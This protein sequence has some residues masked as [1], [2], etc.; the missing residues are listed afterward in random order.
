MESSAGTQEGQEAVAKRPLE[1]MDLPSEI[2]KEII[3]HASQAD[4]IC[5]SLVSKHFRELAAAQLYRNFNI[6]FPDEDDPQYDSPIDGLAGGLDTF[7]TS[8]YDYAQHLRD[9]SLDTLSAGHK[10]E[11]AYKPYLASLSCG[12]FMNTLLLLTLRKAKKLET[13]KWNIRVELSR[14]VYKELHRIESLSHLHIRLQEGPSIYEAPPPLPYHGSAVPPIVTSPYH[15]NNTQH[16]GPNGLALSQIIPQVTV[17]TGPPGPSGFYPITT[18]IG[19]GNNG[20]SI[21][22][23]MGAP[24]PQPKPP[25]PRPFK[26]VTLKNEPPTF[27]GFKKLKSLSVLDIDS[28]DIITEIKSCVRNSAG[29]LQKVKLSFS[30]K[31]ASQARKPPPE[32]DPEDSDVDDDFQVAPPPMPAYMSEASGPAKAFRAQEERKTQESVL[33]RIFDLEVFMVKKAQK[34]Q[35]EKEKGKEKETKSEL[36]KDPGQEFIRAIKMVANRLVKEL[37]DESDPADVKAA[38]QGILDTIEAAA[39]KYLDSREDASNSKAGGS[40]SASGP[41]KPN[42][43]PPPPPAS[44]Q[45]KT[46]A[47]TPSSAAAQTPTE[48]SSLFSQSSS[49]KVTESQKGKGIAPEDINIE[50]PEEQLSLDSSDPPASLSAANEPVVITR[51][52]TPTPAV[53]SR[54]NLVVVPPEASKAMANLAAQRVNFRT[55]AEKL[56]IFEAQ[57]DTL[58]KHIAQMR[59][60]NSPVDVSRIAEAEKEMSVISHNIQDIHKELLTVE[61]EIGDAEKQMPTSIPVDSVEV[62]NQRMIDYQRRT[63]GVPLQSF[64]VY[65]MPVK[66]SILSK[67][68]D[69]RMLRSLTL[70][71]VGIQAPIWTHLTNLNRDQPLP[72]RKIFT[73][74]VT[75]AF[76]TFVYE[77]EELEQLFMLERDA[78]Y[79]PEP[80]S[81]KTLVTMDMIRKA[82]LKK[83]VH[84]IKRLMIK[85]QSNTSWDLD[86]KSILL[87]C[88][89]GRQLE[90]LSCAMSI[91]SLHTFM[92]RIPGLVNLRALHIFQLRNEDTC[93]WVMREAKRFLIDNLSHYPELKLEWISIDEDDRVER[94]IRP[95]DLPKRDRRKHS[96]HNH[97]GKGK[98]KVVVVPGIEGWP[99]NIGASSSTMAPPV[100]GWELNSDSEDD[101]DQFRASKIETVGELHFYDVY[102]VKIFKKEVIKGRL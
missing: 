75:P 65:L 19:F 11:E 98:Q 36:S 20:P 9:L 35:R 30:D 16:T 66:A 38:Q 40:S 93:V 97:K 27:S 33:G 91:R 8:D 100:Q 18:V 15:P 51:Q 96:N 29:T 2:Q 6:V 14:P 13:F 69:L 67:A 85:N 61:L 5:L 4:W 101:D 92:Q 90:E 48:T 57:A 87:L 60:S 56:D 3:R 47:S 102:G 22:V 99:N 46:Q 45:A 58:S 78:K 77:L 81:P 76:L 23:S 64:A 88:G 80:F 62:Q 82:V 25:K 1:F 83:H 74:N 41:S 70:L 89:L 32:V 73:D 79:K 7:A 39:R 31:L 84:H 21:P 28:L 10:A 59:A 72:L 17:P 50:E 34:K 49:S 26:K 53:S 71:N 43:P 54:P 68:I 12:K 86:E 37:G 94:L 24:P 44:A 55:L 95:S 42:Y 63:R 52:S